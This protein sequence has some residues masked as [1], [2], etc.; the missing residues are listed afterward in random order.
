MSLIMFLKLEITVQHIFICEL[1]M[2]L[3][4]TSDVLVKIYRTYSTKTRLEI[5]IV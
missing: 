2:T 4:I 1:M 3:D 5:A